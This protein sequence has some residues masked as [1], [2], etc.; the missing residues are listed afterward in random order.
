MRAA[1]FIIATARDAIMAYSV[2]II[3]NNEIVYLKVF[4]EVGIWDYEKGRDAAADIMNVN[5]VH[6][7]LICMKDAVIKTTRHEALVFTSDLADY[8]LFI[9]KIAL[10]VPP[11]N[12]YIEFHK[13]FEETARNHDLNLAVFPD[14]ESAAEWLLGR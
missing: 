1:G 6:N 5:A 12:P 7:L 4:D 10:V 14:H 8:F 3:E 13:Y 2:D 9:V 11:D